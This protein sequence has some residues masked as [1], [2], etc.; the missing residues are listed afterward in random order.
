MR[1]YYGFR[2]QFWSWVTGFAHI[3]DGIFGVLTLGFYDPG[4]HMIGLEKIMKAM[5]LEHSKKGGKRG[6]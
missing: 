2:S 1:K 3:V 5:F 6:S 4:L